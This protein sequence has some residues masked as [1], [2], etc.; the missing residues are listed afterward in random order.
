[1]L[2]ENTIFLKNYDISEIVGGHLTY[3]DKLDKILR[4]IEYENW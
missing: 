4:Y 3:R 1:L 2:S